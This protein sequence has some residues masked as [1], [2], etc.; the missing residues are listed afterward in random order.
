MAYEIKRALEKL[1]QEILKDKD[2]VERH[3]QKTI[4]EIKTYDK[5][6]MFNKFH[7][8]KKT[9]LQKLLIILGN[10]KKR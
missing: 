7:V 6:I 8:K 1:E 5:S 10:G 9:F 3:K 4:E 2:Q